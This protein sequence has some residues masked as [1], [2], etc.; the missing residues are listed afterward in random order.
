MNQ[1]RITILLTNQYRVT[2]LLPL[3]GYPTRPVTASMQ[4]VCFVSVAFT[5]G[6]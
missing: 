5:Q 4:R 1:Y 2:I 3:A 6:A